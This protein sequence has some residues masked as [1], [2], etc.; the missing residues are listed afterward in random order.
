MSGFGFVK[1]RVR[2][3]DAGEAV[4]V[5]GHHAQPDQT[6]PVL[7]DQRR[8]RHL[9]LPQPGV[10][11]GDLPLERVV[12]AGGRLVGPAEADQ[13]RREH[14]QPGAGEDRDHVPVQVAPR[15]LAVHAEHDRSVARALVD[16][17]DPQRAA[18]SVGNLGVVGLEGVA[19]QIPEPLV[20]RAMGLH[21]ATSLCGAERAERIMGPA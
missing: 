13:V 20:G 14:A 8:P 6:A 11:P 10:Q 4:R 7:S 9:V 1:P 2:G 16:V 18:V 3:D 21:A 15:R 5:L 19:G 12:L 17:V